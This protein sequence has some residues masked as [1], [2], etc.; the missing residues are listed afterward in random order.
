MVPSLLALVLFASAPDPPAL[1]GLPACHAVV[2]QSL[3]LLP[4]VS[5][6]KPVRRATVRIREYLEYDDD[7]DGEGAGRSGKKDSSRAA[8]PAAPAGIRC[9]RPAWPDAA[10]RPAATS[11]IYTLCTLLL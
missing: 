4:T 3:G 2:R 11:L 10:T 6:G 5:R 7:S 1:S 9:L 8:F